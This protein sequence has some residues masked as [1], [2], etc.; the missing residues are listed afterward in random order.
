MYFL[1]FGVSI[2]AAGVASPSQLLQNCCRRPQRSLLT[3][4]ADHYIEAA[5]GWWML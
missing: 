4:V 1:L 5:G 2:G 3:V